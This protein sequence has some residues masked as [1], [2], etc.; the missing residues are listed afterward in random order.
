MA[1]PNTYWVTEADLLQT[2]GKDDVKDALKRRQA[3]VLQELDEA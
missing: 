3:R 1:E 2:I